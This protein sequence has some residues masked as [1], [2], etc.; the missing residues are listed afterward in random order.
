MTDSPG[1]PLTTN[2]PGLNIGSV[3]T[4]SAGD[5]SATLT[6]SH[7]GANFNTPRTL[8]V[9]VGAAAHTLTGDLATRTVAVMPA[10]G[11]VVSTPSLSLAEAPGATNANVGTYT[12]VLQSPPS[13]DVTVTATSADAAVTL[14]TDSTP[15]TKTLTF[16]TANWATAQTVTATAQQD[17]DAADESV[18]VTHA[19]SGYGGVTS[20]ASV[21]VAVDDDEMPG[22]AIDAN[23]AT[24][25]VDEPGPLSLAE[26]SSAMANSASYTVRLTVQPT[27]TVTV[28]VTSGDANAVAVRDTDG[29]NTNGVQNTLTFTTANWA[30]AQTVTLVAQQDDDSLNENV[31]VT[32][33]ASTAATSE[34]TNVSATIRATVADD[35]VAGFVFDADPSTPAVDDADPLKLEELASS[36]TNSGSYSVR[37]STQ[38]SQTVTVT[39]TSQDTGAVAV[40]VSTLTF[41]ATNWNTAQTVTVT[42]QQDDDGAD[43]SVDITH[44]AASLGR[45]YSRVS[46]DFEVTV[47]DDETAAITLSP[48]SLSVNEQNNAAYTVALATQPT[49][50]VTI[51][52]TGAGSGISIDV[53]SLT[54]TTTNWNTALFT[55]HGPVLHPLVLAAQTFIIPDR[56]KNFSAKKAVPLRLESPI[57]YGLRLSDFSIAP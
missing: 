26:L 23:P 39:V 17:D 3:A 46:G 9:T 40:G 12:V 33:A 5:T 41:T 28:T 21:T 44:W 19:V 20:A 51:A 27:A 14:D 37:L 54:F 29:D 35:D 53:S 32:N 24:T 4:V 36:G 13:G 42:A 47:D 34:Y 2:V 16:T 49:D 31:V 30:T 1:A 43:E 22:I 38:P 50:G 57:V 11:V 25:S 56:P 8:S 52:I 48:T 55:N 45:A 18:S 6:L 10:P 7:T 15:L